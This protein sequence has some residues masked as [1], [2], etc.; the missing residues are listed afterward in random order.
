MDG[1]KRLVLGA[2]GSVLAVS[3]IVGGVALAQTPTPQQAPPAPDQGNPA[4]KADRDCPEK[5]GQ[6]GTGLRG[7][8]RPAGGV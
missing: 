5:D 3:A 8:S 2:A 4:P 1:L 6:Q 7:R